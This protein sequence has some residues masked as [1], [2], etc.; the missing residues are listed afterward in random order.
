M[1]TQMQPGPM[2]L[3]RRVVRAVF[4]EEFR[5]DY[6]AEMAHTFGAQHRD[7]HSAGRH[8]VARL[9]WDTLVGFARTAPREHVA[10]LRQD[11]AYALRM[12][13]RAPG[14]TAVAVLT[15]ATG[16][17]ANTAIFGVVN[18]VLLRPLPYAHADAVFAVRNVLDGARDF[19]FSNPELLDARE[20]LRAVKVAAYSKVTLNLTGRGEPERLRGTDIT[21][22]ALDVL[23]VDPVLGRSFRP[24]EELPGRGRVAILSH[25]LWLRVFNGDR[26]A[27]G[28]TLQLDGAPYEVV[29][30]LPPAFVAPDE[31][32]SVQRSALL[33]PLTLD[34]AAPRRER[35]SHYLAALAS[36]RAGYSGA[37]AQSELN[38]LVAAFR[39][40]NPGEYDAA[41]HA[42]LVPL[43]TEIVGDVRRPLL[44]MLGAVGFVLL[45]A[46]A[47]VANLLLARTQVRAREIAVRR[48]LGASHSRLVRQVLTESLVLAAISAAGGA[49]LARAIQTLVVRSATSIPRIADAGLDRDALLFTGLVSVLTALVFGSLP[50]AHLARGN[51]AQLGARSGGS[52][53]RHRVRAVLVAAQVALTIVLLVGAG[54]LMRSFANVLSVPSGFNPERVLTLSLTVPNAG[55]ERR[56]T[57][58]RLFEQ[59]LERVRSAPGIINAGA[60]AGLPVQSQRGDWDFYMEGETPGPGGS[61]RPADWQV[62]TPG[63]FETMG[64]R[65]VAGRHLTPNDRTDSPAVA[66]INETLA[67]TF[68]AA[69]DPI[70]RRIRMSGDDRPWMTIVGVVGDV[71]QDG[72]DAPPTPEIY[73]PHSQFRPFWRDSTLRGF[74]VVVRTHGDPA[75]AVAVVR[76]HLRVLDPALPIASVITMRDVVDRSVAERRLHTTLLAVFAGIALVLAVVGTYG[77]LAYQITERTREFGVRMALG[78]RASDIVGM[79]LRQG[80]TPALVGVIAGLGG[81]VLLTRLIAALLFETEPLDPVTFGATTALLLLAALGACL[82]PARRAT[83]VDPTTALRAE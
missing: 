14:F 34:P 20:R 47:N 26:R 15:L 4:P 17:G 48:A 21:W 60:V 25:D 8:A 45:I 12:M 6:E 74:T 80:M 28:Q 3:F 13:A 59:L 42:A 81:A 78:A 38:T 68:F 50:A 41:Y 44:I 70:G 52:P 69:T 29:G 19:G 63:Y 65:L 18:A 2:R 83:H 39:R 31:F 51:A 73:M 11:V 66:L 64:I 55:Y 33:V 58:V 61:D 35:G 75:G 79:V 71:R 10:Q 37:Q 9:W 49:L 36:P 76:E 54:L 82:I 43:R 22:N 46:C 24:E 1:S 72:L 27:L 57:V 53:V 30:V 5:T 56:E 77:V 62:V 7:A 32:A 23:G 40:E 67:R 16:R